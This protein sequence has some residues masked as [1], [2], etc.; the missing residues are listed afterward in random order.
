MLRRLIVALLISVASIPC[1]FGQTWVQVRGGSYT[2]DPA[3]LSHIRAALEATVTHSARVQK[4]ELAPWQTYTLQYQPQV[5][6][7]HRVVRID[8]ACRVHPGANLQDSFLDVADG[9]PCYFTVTYSIELGKFSN[10]LFN[11]YA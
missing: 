6:D 9:G 5:V 3:V 7:G 4:A 10:V 11:G 2:L 8:G 1:G